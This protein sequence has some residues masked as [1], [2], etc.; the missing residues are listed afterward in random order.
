MKRPNEFCTIK[1]YSCCNNNCINSNLSDGICINGNGY[2]NVHKNEITYNNS[3]TGG[4]NKW[5]F[6]HSRHPFAKTSGFSN[7]YSLFYF[8]VTIYNEGNDS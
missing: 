5:I 3:L 6:I 2:I 7:N 1:I 8:E 4:E